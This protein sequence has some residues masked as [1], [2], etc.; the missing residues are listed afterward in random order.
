ICITPCKFPTLCS[1][2]APA[3][4]GVGRMCEGKPARRTNRARGN[5][6]VPRGMKYR[7][8]RPACLPP[9]NARRGVVCRQGCIPTGCKAAG[10]AINQRRATPYVSGWARAGANPRGAPTG[11]A[12]TPSFRAERNT[13]GVAVRDASL[14]D[15]TLMGISRFLPSGTFLRNVRPQASPS[16]SV[17]QRP[18]FR[19]WRVRGQ[20]RAA[21]QRN[22]GAMFF[23]ENFAE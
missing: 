4:L 12:A 10:L 14:Q 9:N 21:H 13:V 3:Q 11:Q 7:R 16:I 2:Q 19:G 8:G 1:G 20:T 6:A 18:T 23:V 5:A 17:G 22:M 15:A